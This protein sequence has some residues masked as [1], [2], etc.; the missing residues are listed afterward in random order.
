MTT[1]PHHKFWPRRLPHAIHPPVTPL[2]DNLAISARRYPDKAAIVFF[3]REFRYAEV[4]H[5]AGRLAARPF[6]QRRDAVD[7]RR[8]R[9]S[10]LCACPAS[11]RWSSS[12]SS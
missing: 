11:A 12:S 6:V 2:W 7:R 4:M 8:R 1:R 5:L 9:R 10:T 3:G